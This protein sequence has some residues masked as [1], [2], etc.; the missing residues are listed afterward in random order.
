M[1]VR[2][3]YDQKERLLSFNVKKESI[4]REK[5]ITKFLVPKA[6]IY[7]RVS[8][9]KQVADGNGLRSQEMTCRQWCEQQNPPIEVDSV[10]IEP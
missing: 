3:V 9:S 6:V 8:S 1:P 7:C 10:F 2:H 4:K 5:V